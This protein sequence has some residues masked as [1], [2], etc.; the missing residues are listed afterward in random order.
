MR[1]DHS[2]G[3][4]Y[5]KLHQERANCQGGGVLREDQQR[6]SQDGKK[7][8]NHNGFSA[9][10]LL[11]KRAE[12]QAARNRTNRGDSGDCSHGLG[13]IAAIASI[14]AISGGLA[15][16]AFSQQIGRRKA[17]VIAALLS[18]LAIPLLVFSQ[19]ATTLAIGAFLMQFLVQGAWGVI[20]A[21][22]N[23]LSPPEVR[24]TFPGFSYQLG[25]FF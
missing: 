15:F 10:D 23:E 16:G 4:L 2:P 11:G 9:T 25:N 1:W 20:P 14:G 17:I 21:H 3:A 13:I 12:R 7:S 24:G 18:I 8:R 6:D 5:E 22:L 19:D